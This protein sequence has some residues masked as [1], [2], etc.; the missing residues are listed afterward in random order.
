MVQIDD[1]LPHRLYSG[2]DS[3]EAIHPFGI[4]DIEAIVFLNNSDESRKCK[5]SNGC[6]QWEFIPPKYD[7]PKVSYPLTFILENNPIDN[8]LNFTYYLLQ[9]IKEKILI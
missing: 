1:Y 4:G 9:K 7:P 5:A 3:L 6:Q 2:F 8:Y